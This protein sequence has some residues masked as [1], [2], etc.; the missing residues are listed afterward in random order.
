M[1]IF[2]VITKSVG[3]V[4]FEFAYN[5]IVTNGLLVFQDSFGTFYRL[6]NMDDVL[7][8]IAE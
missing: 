2:T 6:F 8:V 1:K 5:P 7:S 4:T 3:Q